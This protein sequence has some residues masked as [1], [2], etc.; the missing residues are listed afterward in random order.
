[1]KSTN[2]APPSKALDIPCRPFFVPIPSL[3]RNVR[4]PCKSTLVTDPKPPT[5]GMPPS[6]P[7]TSPS[8]L[9]QYARP[10][11]LFISESGAGGVAIVDSKRLVVRDESGILLGA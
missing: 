3:A 10:F 1:M 4:E 6:M 9:S 11:S 8:V 7:F 2:P 5:P